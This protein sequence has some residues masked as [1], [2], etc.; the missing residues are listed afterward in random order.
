MKIFLRKN[1]HKAM[2]D[3]KKIVEKDKYFQIL[4]R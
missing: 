1:G 3:L 2:S 4:L